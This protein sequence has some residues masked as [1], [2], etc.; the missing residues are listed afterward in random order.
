MCQSASSM[1]LNCAPSYWCMTTL[2]PR[3]CYRTLGSCSSTGTVSPDMAVTFIVHRACVSVC[4]SPSRYADAADYPDYGQYMAA[5]GP[6]LE[7][8]S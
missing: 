3:P 4:R 6:G 8:C 2:T 7:V 5:G 1:T